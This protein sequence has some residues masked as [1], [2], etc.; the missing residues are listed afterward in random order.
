M[1][2]HL[3][4]RGWRRFKLE[5]YHLRRMKRWSGLYWYRWTDVNLISIQKPI[6]ID[7]IGLRNVNIAKKTRTT[8]WDT[9]HKMKWGK[10]GKK[11][12]D[13]SSDPNTRVKDKVRFQR[14]LREYG[15]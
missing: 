13:Y 3:R 14:E 6:W 2:N 9:R 12:Y 8:K 1:K 5:C 11:N 15:Y 10:K 7:S 4:D